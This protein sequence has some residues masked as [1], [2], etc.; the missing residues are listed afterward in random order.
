VTE[1][2]RTL[3]E[4]AQELDYPQT[5]SLA[6]AVEQRLRAEH[7]ARPLRKRRLAVALAVAFV[8]P[9]AAFAAVPS[10]RDAVLELF[11]SRGVQIVRT[12]SLLPLPPAAKLELGRPITLTRAQSLLGFRVLSPHIGELGAPDEAYYRP[13]PAGGALSLVYRARAGIPRSPFTTRGLLLTEFRGTDAPVFARKFVGAG[14][15][16][17]P[18]SVNGQAGVWLAGRPHEFAYLDEHGQT[19]TESLRLAGNTLLW[20]RGRLTLRLEGANSKATAL[21]IARSVR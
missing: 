10:I 18:V 13:F 6:A 14:T 7:P 17:E 5:P 12:P 21:G 2:E 1:L 3:R 15:S 16:I 11:G 4:L 19:Q 8:L 20:V 9:T